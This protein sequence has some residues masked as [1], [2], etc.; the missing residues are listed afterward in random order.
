MPKKI[1]NAKTEVDLFNNN[2]D[3]N[4]TINDEEIINENSTNRRRSINEINKMRNILYKV[5]RIGDDNQAYWLE[6]TKTPVNEEYLSKKYKRGG[7]YVI[8]PHDTTKKNG[9]IVGRFK[10]LIDEFLFPYQ[11]PIFQQQPPQQQIA[12]YNPDARRIDALEEKLDQLTDLIIHQSEQKSQPSEN[13]IKQFLQSYQE[14]NEI[15]GVLKKETSIINPEIEILKKELRELKKSQEVSVEEQIEEIWETLKDLKEIIENNQKGGVGGIWEKLLPQLLPLILKS[16]A[17]L[18][19]IAQ[20]QQP[21]PPKPNKPEIPQEPK[22]NGFPTEIIQLVKWY[23]TLSGEELQTAKKNLVEKL[24]SFGMPQSQMI[25]V[26]SALPEN[27]TRDGSNTRK[28]I[29]ELS[30]VSSPS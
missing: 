15:A 21:E 25:K 6:T 22:K 7:E 27:V 3:N 9:N 24:A 19:G 4:E 28:L 18:E 20:Q 13:P 11:E 8:I 5:Y 23:D 1:P 29:R 14:M 10:I 26:L 30:H 12:G 17:G 16:G 2:N